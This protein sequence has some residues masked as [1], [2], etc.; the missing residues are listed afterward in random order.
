MDFF[1]KDGIV[2]KNMPAG[3]MGGGVTGS[4]VVK[5]SAAESAAFLASVAEAAPM[6]PPA[7]VQIM[8]PAADAKAID[9]EVA[10]EEVDAAHG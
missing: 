8:V 5:A 10:K 6:A 1:E 4:V 9:D 3:G 7:E 2:Y